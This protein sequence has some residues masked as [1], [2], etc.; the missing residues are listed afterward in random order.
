MSVTCRGAWD[1]QDFVESAGF[2]VHH[3]TTQP[4]TQ[5]LYQDM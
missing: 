5:G 1:T 3:A 2:R 4:E